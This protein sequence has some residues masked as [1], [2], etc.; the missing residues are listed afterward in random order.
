VFLTFAGYRVWIDAQP[1][2]FRPTPEDKQNVLWM[3]VRL[4]ARA[5]A[6]RWQ[7]LVKN[8]YGE[9]VRTFSGWDAPP[10]R[11][12]WDGLDDDGRLVGDGNYSYS[13]V[14]VDQHNRPLTFSGSLTHIRTSG[15]KGRLEVRPQ[16]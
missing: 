6:K 14:V 13:I 1:A 12:T 5:G 8:Q 15:P 2:L 9:V 11:M 16:H 4:M 7:V 3:D 10:L